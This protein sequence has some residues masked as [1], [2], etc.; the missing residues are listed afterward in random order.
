[1]LQKSAMMGLVL[2]LAIFLES[3]AS[4]SANRSGCVALSF[5]VLDQ[6]NGT[7]LATTVGE[8]AHVQC[9]SGFVYSGEE[10][11]CGISKKICLAKTSAE[12]QEKQC[13]FEYVFVLSGTALK[14]WSSDAELLL[15]DPQMTQEDAAKTAHEDIAMIHA[16]LPDTVQPNAT[17]KNTGHNAGGNA[18]LVVGAAAQMED[19]VS[20]AD[21]TGLVS[22]FGYAELTDLA[23]DAKDN[24]REGLLSSRHLKPSNPNVVNVSKLKCVRAN[25]RK[26]ALSVSPIHFGMKDTV[27]SP[28]ILTSICL[29]AFGVLLCA[30]MYRTTWFALP[31][32]E[33]DIEQE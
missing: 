14:K 24:V 27:F 2:I 10:L 11:E 29:L 9:P 5:E 28:V 23:A 19:S 3:T 26:D 30:L 32:V 7:V 25:E 4:L 13:F 33:S 6:E 20:D 22:L 15:R 16:S 8:I 31:D 12:I 1:M 17:T 18:D 21:A